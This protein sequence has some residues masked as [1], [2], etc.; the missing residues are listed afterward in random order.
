MDY[1][2]PIQMLE[3]E[4]LVNAKVVGATPILAER[5]ETGMEMDIDI[6][7]GVIEFMRGFTDK[8]RHGKE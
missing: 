8:R 6:L 2:H 3:N 4:H 1:D 5:L 7:Q